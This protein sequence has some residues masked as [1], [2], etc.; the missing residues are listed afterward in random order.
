M[1]GFAN[2]S[3]ELGGVSLTLDLRAV[4]HRYLEAQFRMPDELRVVEP[5]MRELISSRLSRGKVDCRIQLNIQ[6]GAQTSLSLNQ[7]MLEQLVG[8]T[9][10]VKQIFPD[11]GDL[12]MGELLRWPGV[13][14]TQDVP[15]ELLQ[16]TVLEML[17]QALDDFTA[18]RGREGAKLVEMILQRVDRMEVLVTEVEPKIPALLAAYQ[19]KISLRLKEAMV[20]GEDD[21]IRQEFA[22]FAQKID[23]DEE[24][25]RLRTHLSE[26][27]RILKAGGT[28]GKRMDFLMQEL[29]REANTLGSKSVSAEV[30]QTSMEL[31][32]LIEQMREQIQNIE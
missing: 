13:L 19:E 21:R 14:E 26:L 15:A 11:A 32:V 6:T 10:Q 25:S 28:V 30:S 5:Q 27:R 17:A 24:I 16:Q 4:N 7:T 12:K 31:K 22:L 1:T 20:N 23:V 9:R 18:S 8:L 29:N 3:R 2:A